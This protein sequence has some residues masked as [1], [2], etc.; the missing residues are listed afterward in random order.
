MPSYRLSKCTLYI[1]SC[2]TGC[3]ALGSFVSNVN[4]TFTQNF[5]ASSMKGDDLAM[6][7]VY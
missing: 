3:F 7:I 5:F 2:T 4:Q 1:R 6:F